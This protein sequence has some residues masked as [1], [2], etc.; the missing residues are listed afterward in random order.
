M[1]GSVDLTVNLGATASGATCTAG[2]A[3]TATAASRAWLQGNW[4]ASTWDRNPAGRAAFGI[5][6]ASPDVIYQRETY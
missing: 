4:G 5:P 6:G 1:R 3:A 2:S